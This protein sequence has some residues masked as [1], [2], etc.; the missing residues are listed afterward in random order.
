M[1]SY[2]PG[3]HI[4]QDLF[5]SANDELNPLV[6]RYQLTVGN[7]DRYLDDDI[8]VVVKACSAVC[9]LSWDETLSPAL[10]IKAD[11]SST[12]HMYWVKF[13]EPNEILGQ[14][15][16]QSIYKSSMNS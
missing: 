11:L 13:S 9:H 15:T 3:V 2:T 16:S 5:R 6:H 12:M 10:V 1:Y 14:R 8:V 4:V 7:D